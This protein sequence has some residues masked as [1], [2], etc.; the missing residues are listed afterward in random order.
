MTYLLVLLVCSTLVSV[1]S[2]H[3]RSS[4]LGPSKEDCKCENLK[5]PEY[6]IVNGTRSR[7]LE[8]GL[9]WI[10]FL[11]TKENMNGI[12]MNKII[13]TLT[14]IGRYWALTGKYKVGYLK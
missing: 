10:G 5:E 7:A 2:F 3:A 8:E 12:L 4:Q 14:I 11:F 13:C 9:P 6:R 1:Q